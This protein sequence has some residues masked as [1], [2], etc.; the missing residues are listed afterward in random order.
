[1][2]KNEEFCH[3]D[4]PGRFGVFV[5]L[6]LYGDGFILNVIHSGTYYTS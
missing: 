2:P 5:N 3:L 6:F 1:M 4:L